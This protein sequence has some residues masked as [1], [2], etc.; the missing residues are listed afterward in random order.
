[1][2]LQVFAATQPGGEV[3]PDWVVF[4]LAQVAREADQGRQTIATAGVDLSAAAQG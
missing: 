4:V 2:E 1:M 3:I